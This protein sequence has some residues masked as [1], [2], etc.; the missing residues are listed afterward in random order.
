MLVLPFFDSEAMFI[1]AINTFNPELD[2]AYGDVN[3][4]QVLWISEYDIVI[5]LNDSA[6]CLP[7]FVAFG[8]RCHS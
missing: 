4:F 2:M 5:L 7:Q 6:E 3:K 8:L 1:R